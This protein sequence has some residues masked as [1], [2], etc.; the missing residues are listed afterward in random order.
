MPKRKQKVVYWGNPQNDGY[1]GK[2]FDA[3]VEILVRWEDKQELYTDVE[4]RE[5][6]STA[7]VY[8]GV[9]LDL[10]GFLYLGELDDSGLDSDPLPN[11]V[12]EA[13][14]IQQFWKV[15]N[16]RA[17]KFVRKAWL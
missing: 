9:D 11:E 7:V 15:P 5:V 14:E 8:P 10:G 2:T 1:G 16:L 17:T 13:K 6:R 12:S 3:A 4:G